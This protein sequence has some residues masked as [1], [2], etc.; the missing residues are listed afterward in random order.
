MLRKFVFLVA[1]L[2]LVPAVVLAAPVKKKSTKARATVARHWNGYGFL[3][4]YAPAE[5]ARRGRRLREVYRPRDYYYHGPYQE[6]VF[7]GPYVYEGRRVYPGGSGFY[8]NQWNGGSF[9]PCYTSTPIGMM[10][11]CGK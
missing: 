2:V 3:P 9:G 1:A 11:N 10:W 8:R 4:G 7:M 5:A 6:Y